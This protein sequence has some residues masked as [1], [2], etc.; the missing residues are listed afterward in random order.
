VHRQTAPTLSERRS[1]AD[2]EELLN[3]ARRYFQAAAL[4]PERRKMQILVKLGLEYLKLAA[5]LER[6][7]VRQ[8]RATPTKPNRVLQ[9]PAREA[10]GD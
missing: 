2:D 7:R 8:R 9:A 4:S 3:H 5:Q 6:S 1:A 10:A